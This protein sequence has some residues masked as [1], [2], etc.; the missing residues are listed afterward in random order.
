MPTLSDINDFYQAA[1][2]LK[3]AFDEFE[4]ALEKIPQISVSLPSQLPSASQP[5][6]QKSVV[7]PKKK[8]LESIKENNKLS[9][10]QLVI[11]EYILYNTWC[12][13]RKIATECAISVG[14]IMNVLK[15]LEKRKII[16]RYY[17]KG[18]P[19]HSGSAKSRTFM[20]WVCYPTLSITPASGSRPGMLHIPDGYGL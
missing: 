18:N 7:D 3:K 12:S 19:S 11:V 4:K 9:K 1:N 8:I 16:S 5:K 13:A 2:R 6:K 10:Q 15:G 14:K 20:Y 17:A